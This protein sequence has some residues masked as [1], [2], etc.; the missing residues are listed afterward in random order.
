MDMHTN[1]VYTLVG[2]I[3]IVKH[4]ARKVYK[5]YRGDMVSHRWSMWG[6]HLTSQSCR[7]SF[8]KALASFNAQPRQV[9]K[10]VWLRVFVMTVSSDR[11][12]QSPAS[13][14][15]TEMEH[16]RFISTWNVD[17]WSVFPGQEFFLMAFKFSRSHAR[18]AR[19]QERSPR[20]WSD[21]DE[22]L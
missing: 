20:P 1:C 8:Q 11:P 21:Y 10:E 14:V 4:M 22:P 2:H 6:C 15:S 9:F 5:L 19:T 16:T 18:D 17:Q 7:L 12:P 3:R 13:K